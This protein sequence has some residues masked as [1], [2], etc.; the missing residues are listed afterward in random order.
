MN[1]RD[2]IV[3]GHYPADERGRALVPTRCGNTFVVRATD[4]P[5]EYPIVGWTLVGGEG[6][7]FTEHGT[8]RNHNESAWLMLPS[9]RKVKLQGW[10]LVNI[11]HPAGKAEIAWSRDNLIR[12]AGP[13]PTGTRYRLVELTG[14]YEEPWS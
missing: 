5:R 4:G 14:E 8:T 1:I 11:E 12:N 10:A 3:A 13:D 6:M 7:S 2:H 9:P